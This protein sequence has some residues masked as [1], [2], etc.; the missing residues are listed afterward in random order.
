MRKNQ[1][2]VRE[3]SEQFPYRFLL[4]FQWPEHIEKALRRAMWAWLNELSGGST[5]DT[6]RLGLHMCWLMA[7]HP[8]TPPA[9]LDLL[10]QQSSGALLERVAE[11]PNAWPTT[12]AR[13][14]KNPCSHVRV[15][16]A[17]N[18]NTPPET[19]L[20]LARDTCPDVRYSVAENAHPTLSTLHELTEDENCHVAA[21][22]K[23]TIQKMAPKPD[24][25]T[26]VVP[27]LRK[28]ARTQSG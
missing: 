9:V 20:D 28:R 6:D 17:A 15:A 4:R 24:P 14:A 3:N 22:S 26:L 16:V 12:L 5:E 7:V 23:K 1:V 19:V 2:K 8:E 21:R 27:Q 18:H 11:N 25:A 10:A 13:L